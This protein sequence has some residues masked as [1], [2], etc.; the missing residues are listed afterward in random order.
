MTLVV[1]WHPKKRLRRRLPLHQESDQKPGKPGKAWPGRAYRPFCQACQESAAWESLASLAR[2]RLSRP[3]R[4]GKPG[5]P[6]HEINGTVKARLSRQPRHGKAGLAGH[7]ILW[8]G[9][10]GQAF[11]ITSARKAR[12]CSHRWMPTLDVC[13][14]IIYTWIF[15]NRVNESLIFFEAVLILRLKDTVSKLRSKEVFLYMSAVFLHLL[16]QLV[17]WKREAKKKKQMPKKG[18]A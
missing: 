11:K 18:N 7:E 14:N 16:Q 13:I 2:A 8:H 3:S 12:P 6:G 4:H 17:A 9:Q 15:E 10:Q 1:A 5:L